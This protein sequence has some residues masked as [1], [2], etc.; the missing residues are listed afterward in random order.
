M[1]EVRPTPINL[2]F[3]VLGLVLAVV[4]FAAFVPIARCGICDDLWKSVKA[5]PVP[6]AFDCPCCG[7][8]SM[9]VSLIH[10]WLPGHQRHID[11]L[12]LMFAPGLRGSSP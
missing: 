8:T 3:I 9:R 1:S 6:G 5:E 2:T 12:N 7:G 4:A 11:R 10:K